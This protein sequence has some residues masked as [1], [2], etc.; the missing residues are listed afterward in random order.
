M[1]PNG[2]TV[3]YHALTKVVFDMHANSVICAS[4]LSIRVR[5]L[6]CSYTVVV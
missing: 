4:G 6:G 5:R 3:F 1:I 2:L